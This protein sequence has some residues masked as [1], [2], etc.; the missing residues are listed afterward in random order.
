MTNMEV[1]KTVDEE[2][3]T[4]T[5]VAEE[6]LEI[7]TKEDAPV[8]DGEATEVA[9]EADMKDELTNEKEE[10]EE[11]EE[12]DP[13]DA[14]FDELAKE[15]LAKVNIDDLTAEL[16]NEDLFDTS[17]ADAVLNLASLTNVVNK[18]EEKEEIVLDTF[19]DKDPFDTSAYDHI[20]RE[21]EDDLDFDS[22]AKRDPNETPNNNGLDDMG[23]YLTGINRL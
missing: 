5:E 19:D 15:S 23:R 8:K 2:P 22:L 18:E 16:Y 1:Q 3:I 9:D 12:D 11:E 13:F 10:E 20:T 17:A 7:E 21:F 6:S 14:A 4:E